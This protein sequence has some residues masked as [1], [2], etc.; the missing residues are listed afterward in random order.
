M[1]DVVLRQEHVRAEIRLEIGVIG[2]AVLIDLIFVRIDDVGVRVPVQ[3]SGQHIQRVRRQ[4]VVVIHQHDEFAMRHFQCRVRGLGD[5]SVGSAKNDFDPLIGAFV[6]SQHGQGF[7]RG[8]GVVGD[9]QLPALVYLL[10]DR[11]D[12]AAQGFRRRVV[13]RHDHREQRIVL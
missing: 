10:A 3:F 1:V 9:A 6:L 11:L 8:R 7:L 13:G 5:V 4:L 2:L 12:G